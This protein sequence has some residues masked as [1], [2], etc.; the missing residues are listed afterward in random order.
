MSYAC[1]DKVYKYCRSSPVTIHFVIKLQIVIMITN[2][3]S[4]ILQC[5]TGNLNHFVIK[6]QIVTDFLDD[7]QEMSKGHSCHV[8]Y[9][10]N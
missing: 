7:L 4:A 6:L 3:M 5:K 10:F 2:R 8:V 1:R 9:R